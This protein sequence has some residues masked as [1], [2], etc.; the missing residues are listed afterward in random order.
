MCLCP[1]ASAAV[2]DR[3]PFPSRGTRNQLSVSKKQDFARSR[4]LRRGGNHGANGGHTNNLCIY[5]G[6]LAPSGWTDYGSGTGAGLAAIKELMR[7]K[8]G[9]A[10]P[11]LPAAV[12]C[13]GTVRLL[14]SATNPQTKPRRVFKH[15]RA[16][17]GCEL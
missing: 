10:R 3:R 14:S 11:P 17:T 12:V 7:I 6:L 16:S 4:M 2:S 1:A 8:N 9:I 15:E 5:A 13:R